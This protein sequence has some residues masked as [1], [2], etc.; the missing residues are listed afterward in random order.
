MSFDRLMIFFRLQTTSERP[1]H[2]LTL[3][4]SL[5]NVKSEDFDCLIIPGGR[6]AEF[7]RLDE[8]VRRIVSEMFASNKPICASGHGT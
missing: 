4:T 5:D 8:N 2:L 1:G 3:T 7:L 6:S